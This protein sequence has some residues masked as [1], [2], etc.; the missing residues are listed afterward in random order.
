MKKIITII[1]FITAVSV[2]CASAQNITSKP[3]TATYNFIMNASIG[4][5]QEIVS[6][7]VAEKKAKSADL[8]SYAAMMITDHNK[9]NA[10]LMQLVK[11]KG[12][13]LPPQ[14]TEKLVPNA[15]LTETSGADFD[16]VYADMMVADHHTTVSI[17]QNYAATGKDPEIKAFAQQTLPILKEHLVV[18]KA[19]AKKVN[20]AS[21]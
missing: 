8:R 3:D 1:T 20:P 14:A 9:A 10:Q 17:F 6:S 12:Y 19:I 2:N 13:R 15:V 5:M 7:N 16:R 18:I 4:G 21:L 11:A